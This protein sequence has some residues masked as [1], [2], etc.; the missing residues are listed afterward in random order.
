[1]RGELSQNMSAKIL[2]EELIAATTSLFE[3]IIVLLYIL[4][5]LATRGRMEVW[6]L[7]GSDQIFLKILLHATSRCCSSGE[8]T[9]HD[10][11]GRIHKETNRKIE[12]G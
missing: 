7:R 2:E 12:T 8:E 5:M 6:H 10:S 9:F 3:R 4:C 11:T 1:M